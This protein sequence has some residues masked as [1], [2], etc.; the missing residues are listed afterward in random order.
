MK[1][2]QLLRKFLLTLKYAILGIMSLFLILTI[3]DF[4]VSNRFSWDPIILIAILGI[5]FYVFLKIIKWIN[6]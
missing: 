2:T 1:K 6:L 3:Y 4:I 5:I